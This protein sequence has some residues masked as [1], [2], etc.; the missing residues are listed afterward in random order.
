MSKRDINDVLRDHDD[1]LLAIPGVAGVYVGLL[2]DEKTLCLKVMVER[3]TPELTAKIPQT[4]EGYRVVVEET[5]V[6]RPMPKK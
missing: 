2:E 1:E 6:I 3:K 5:G 4:L